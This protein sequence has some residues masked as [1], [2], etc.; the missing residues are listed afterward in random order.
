M[1]K[2]IDLK[3]RKFGE[4]KVIEY[5]GNRMWKCRCS[6][7]NIKNIHGYSLTSG[8]TKTCGHG[9]TGFKDLKDQVFG[10]L[11]AKEYLGN[12]YWLCECS[13]GN[14][15]RVH[16]SNLKSGD[17]KSC[18]H[19]LEERQKVQD[20]LIGR[21]FGHLEVLDYVGNKQYRCQCDCKD[22]TIKI[23][24]KHNLISG[25]TTSCGCAQYNT[26]EVDSII[27]AI[28]KYKEE[29]NEA[30]F[31]SDLEQYLSIGKDQIRR[32]IDRYELHDMMNKTYSSR[33]EKEICE[34]LTGVKLHN[35][36]VLDGQELDIYLD[37]V[38]TAIEFNGNYWHSDLVKDK[39]YHQQKTI[40]CARN[41]IRLIHIFEY[42]WE[43]NKEKLVRL[44][45]SLNK[46]DID[47]I[48]AR[49]T[50]V[51][52]ISNKEALEFQEKYHLQGGINSSIN[53]G[54]FYK[55][56]LVGVIS[57]SKPR[58][59]SNYEYEITRLCWDYNYRVIGGLE[60]MFSFFIKEYS[61]TS[62][63]TYVDI[64]KFTGSSYVKVGFKPVSGKFI[65]E[66]NYVWVKEGTNNYLTRYQTQKHKLIKQGLGTKEQTE[67]EIM[68]QL[69]YFKV[70]DSGNLK[71]EWTLN[72]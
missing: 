57:F 26:I 49:K 29:H 13:C 42:E 56:D 35:R 59:N 68:R 6:C 61:P 43:N 1:S 15:K 51:S 47:V 9:T 53:I 21:K 69:G 19:L 50:N 25:G 66:P 40:G 8:K 46:R 16:R 52:I 45:E 55:K 70:Y 5:A 23:V 14:T 72:K 54:C 22:K 18:G 64:S 37:E 27:N 7:N 38:R 41:N 24:Y 60:K 67:D 39:T 32:Y 28:N 30:P 44:L 48:G 65:T 4:L 33:Y 31:Y 63:L 11:T 12:S 36:T 58:F 2:F 71:M 3:G 10:E 62:I 20:R 34:M 17:V